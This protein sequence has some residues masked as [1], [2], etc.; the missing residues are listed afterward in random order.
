MNEPAIDAKAKLKP[1]AISKERELPI[2]PWTW[3][4]APP[5]KLN[6]TKG[7]CVLLPV[8]FAVYY[9]YCAFAVCDDDD[10]WQN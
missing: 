3:F 5:E 2:W 10:D 8:L 6:S 9:F 1:N 7:F 4:M